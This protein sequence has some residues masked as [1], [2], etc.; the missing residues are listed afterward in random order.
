MFSQL[1]NQE[2]HSDMFVISFKSYVN[3]VIST[4]FCV[5]SKSPEI[6]FEFIVLNSK[7]SSA[8]PDKKSGSNRNDRNLYLI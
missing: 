6:S 1:K 8:P 2:N 3:I 5:I 4:T 7:D